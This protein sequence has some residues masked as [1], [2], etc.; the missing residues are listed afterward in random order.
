MEEVEKSSE[1]EH[2]FANVATAQTAATIL[3]TAFW[4]ILAVILHPVA[5]GHLSWLVSIA[6]LTSTICVLGLGKTITTY[7]PKEG[8]DKLIS[9]AI[10]LV[11]MFSI[12]GGSGISLALNSWIEPLLAGMVGLLVVGLS[13]FSLAFYS[14][15]AKRQ[16]SRYM[17][18]WIG[19][20]SSTLVLPLI[21]YYWWGLVAGILAG[22]AVSYF[23]FGIWVL[24]N[25]DS[26]L[27]LREVWKKIEFTLQAWGGDISRAS[28][29]F[30]DKILIGLLF[31]SMAVLGVYQFGYRIFVLLGVLPNALFFYLLPEKSANQKTKK[32]ETIGIL[33]S[34]GLALLILIIAP[35]IASHVFPS[36]QEGINL[37]RI[38]GFAIIPATVARIKTS[39]LY[40]K[41]KSEIVL[42]SRLFALSMGIIGIILTYS[43]S[44]GLIGLGGSQLAIQ[45]ALLIGLTTFPKI[46][47]RDKFGKVTLSLIGML[48]VTALLV[49]SLSAITPD[50]EVRRE[51]VSKKHPEVMDTIATIRVM[52]ENEKEGKMAIDRAFDEIERIEELMSTEMEGSQIYKL[53]HSGTSW[54]KLSTEVI[55]ILKSAQK[56]AKLT[57]GCFDPT[58]K[59]L[60]DL[61]MDKTKKEG[62]MPD[63]GELKEELELVNWNNLMIDE[64]KNRARFRENGMKVTLGGIAKGYAVDRACE[65]LSNNGINSALVNLG[66]DIKA[67]GPKSWK[68]GIQDPRKEGE[69]LGKIEIE[70][71]AIVTS[72]DYRR[73]HWLGSMRIHHIINPKTGRP[74]KGCISVTV[75]A[76]NCMEADALSTGIFVEGPEDG[77]ETLNEMELPGLIVD[78]EEKIITS[79]LW[80]Y[81]LG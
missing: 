10:F 41:E 60:V 79:E 17:W 63:P 55:N 39:E 15:L 3:G 24:R 50:T 54:V 22:L 42:G 80:D 65:V 18:K 8:N 34:L 49:S 35:F 66:G 40:S 32:I 4:L 58:A 25:L 45:I 75:I 9:S 14:E 19:V 46:E 47:K 76:D 62:K 13:L 71:E 61:W 21:F 36:F 33:L 6:T 81:Q 26:D 2:G 69:L 30:F 1:N 44:L 43:E 64:D 37:I 53:N 29:N 68:V 7:Y 16:Y 5:Y 27:D 74:A 73:Y 70:N 23:L 52:T 31:S 77:L 51:S 12:I 57:D 67:F 48:V 56:F 38:M 59:P 28:M 11:L 20:R 72:G 78:S